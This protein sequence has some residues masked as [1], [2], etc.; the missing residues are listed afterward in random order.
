MVD[1][2]VGMEINVVSDMNC[3]QMYNFLVFAERDV[4]KDINDIKLIAEEYELQ[5]HAG[6]GSINSFLN[7]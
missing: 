2:M 1:G 7:Y 6:Y 3:R 4:G 5:D